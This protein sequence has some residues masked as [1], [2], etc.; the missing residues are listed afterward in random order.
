[1]CGCGGIIICVAVGGKFATYMDI[2]FGTAFF[3][4]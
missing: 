2:I 4:I 3:G 1:M